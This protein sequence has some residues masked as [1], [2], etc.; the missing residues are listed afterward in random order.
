MLLT[1]EQLQEIRQVIEDHHH[2]FI[3]NAIDP[4]ALAP[5]VLRR[6]KAKGMIDPSVESIKDSYL[7]GQLVAILESAQVAKMGYDEFKRYL[8]KNPIPL[9]AVEHQAIQMATMS[10]AQYCR[11]LG[12]TVNLD[13][14]AVMIEADAQL[15]ATTE[16]G[17][18]DAVAMNIARRQSVKQLKTDLGW[19][20]KDWA[21]DW[22]RIAVTEKQTAML[23]GQGDAYRKEHGKD[24][25]VAKRVTPDACAHCKRVYRDPNDQPRI[26]KLSTLEANGTNVGRKGIDF[27][28]VLG[29]VHPNCFLKGTQVSTSEGMKP[30]E[31]VLPGDYVLT[32]KSRW[33][34]VTHTWESS[35]EGPVVELELENGNV[36]RGVTGNHLLHSRKG[37][38]LAESLKQ[39]DELL[40]LIPAIKPLLFADLDPEQQPS[41]LGKNRLFA[42]VLHGFSGGGVPVTAVYLNG[43]LYARKSQVDI[44]GFDGVVGDGFE[45]SLDK[46]IV[47]RALVGR[48]DFT[49]SGLG[50]PEKGF[51]SSG[52]T[53]RCDI[54]FAREGFS[55][56]QAHTPHAESIR[57]TP[58]SLNASGFFDAVDNGTSGNPEMSSYVF[59]RHQLVEV[60]VEDG[61]YVEFNPGM[62]GSGF[63]SG[64]DNS[65]F[66]YSPIAN[67][68]LTDYDG[69]VNNY[70]VEDDESYL[71]DGVVSHNCQCQLVR[72]PA[73][74]GFDEKGDLAPD[75]KLGYVYDDEG[76]LMLA[77]RREDDLQKAFALQG[78][79]EFQGMSIAIENRKG[80][81]R[82]WRDAEG[83]SGKTRMKVG[84]G[85]LKRTS[86]A[87]G[88]EIDCF[89]G[90]DP[91]AEN[92]YIVEQ[93]N[94]NNGLYDEAKAMIGF[95][96]Q[97]LAIACYREHYDKPDKFIFTVSPMSVDAF[98]RWA[99]ATAP[100]KANGGLKKGGPRLVVSL[101]KAGPYIG[102]RGGKWADPKLTIPYKKEKEKRSKSEGD[103]LRDTFLNAKTIKEKADASEAW[104]KGDKGHWQDH[105]PGNRSPRWDAVREALDPGH[106]DYK[107]VS[108]W[109]EGKH[110]HVKK[111]MSGGFQK[112]YVARKKKEAKGAAYEAQGIELDGPTQLSKL[113]GKSV[114]LYHGTTT[115]LLARIKKEGL[116]PAVIHGKQSNVGATPTTGA[117]PDYV[118]LTSETSGPGSAEGYAKTAAHAHGGEPV[119]IRVLVDGDDLGRDPDDADITSGSVQFVT[120]SVTPSQLMEVAGKRLKKK[121]TKAR[122]SP[123]IGASTSRADNHAPGPG[124]GANYIF[125]PWP[126]KADDGK[127]RIV[128]AAKELVEPRDTLKDNPLRLKKEDYLWPEP[129]R[130]VVP[131]DLPEDIYGIRERREE[132]VANNMRHLIRNGNKTMGPRNMA[133]VAE[134]ARQ[135]IPKKGANR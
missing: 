5:E 84:Y 32:H 90:P 77:M 113:K 64:H 74:W 29:T 41:V 60:H 39:G 125:L 21:R 24:V 126:K 114:W 20:A 124:I 91:K 8:A 68:R 131:I 13:T 59:Y 85:Y 88:E 80:S 27:R 58:P 3:A 119:I 71:A 87:D 10:A 121:L 55:I 86:G 104:F 50:S 31:Q 81:T 128:R 98:K 57:S 46:P 100:E 120:D 118:Y 7:Y 15:R 96:N 107:E 45:S 43:E 14:G 18:T 9:S 19:M 95:G 105:H 106:K 62:A 110:K 28:A 47:D 79:V 109:I 111:I 49:P 89:V 115:K 65:P 53:P 54:R 73:G 112:E 116:D 102:P 63:T 133:E 82:R 35:Y 12:N 67:V 4:S 99:N 135:P 48:F 26:F 83:N 16:A 123:E 72:I 56:F 37:W 93:L 69:I 70:T 61:V 94:P 36:V 78:H 42:S 30:I 22:T 17:I 2:A 38:V 130:I 97:D 40:S 76:D 108:D 34:R 23:H 51:K 52:T 127:T 117:T 103:Q 25:L 11:G 75:G 92:V 66:E 44:D 1:A 129:A 101:E 6:L 134:A 122:V 132:E 33:R